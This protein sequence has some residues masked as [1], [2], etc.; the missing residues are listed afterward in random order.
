MGTPA[1]ATTILKVLVL[2]KD[3]EVVLLVTQEDKPVGRKQI[4]T[5]PDSKAW[6]I[7]KNIE[8]P[9]YQPKSLRNAEATELIASY[10]PDFIIVAAYGKLLPK[11]ILEIA[12]CINL[13]ASL[14]PLYRGASPIQS[15]LLSNDRYTGVTSM[16]ME[17]GMDTGAMLGFSYHLISE[18]ETAGD[19][20]ERLAQNAAL[21]T[22][23][24]LKNF[25]SLVPLKQVNA[26][27]SHCKKI[28][29]ED[30]EVSFELTADEIM[31][32]FKALTPWPGIFLPSGL[33]LL[34][35]AVLNEANNA[36]EGVIDSF[37]K[38]GIAV[39]CK[40]NALFIKRVQPISKGPMRAV[41]YIRGKR[42]TI[43]DRL[44]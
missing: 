44:A 1:Y 34:D 27:A 28:K 43:G 13:H 31:T 17:E 8:I 26:D 14:L 12:P 39:T 24:S 41:D 20:F 18:P 21:L 4:L 23:L 36:K 11:E 40:E 15:T 19:L 2:D 6:I 16:L 29:K 7:E 30:G 33:K 22:L 37:D 5:P 38:E 10:K 3:C 9:V 35:I 42:L 25:A 32:K